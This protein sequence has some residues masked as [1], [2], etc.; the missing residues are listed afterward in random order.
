M[1]IKKS[2][3]TGIFLAASLGLSACGQTCESTG[4]SS[5]GTTTHS[6]ATSTVYETAQT[7]SGALGTPTTGTDHNHDVTLSESDVTGMEAGPIDVTSTDTDSH[8]HTVSI[9]CSGG[10]F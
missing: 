5:S 10:L 1:K 7:Y 6:H 8:N 3:F 2:L 4:V 9:E